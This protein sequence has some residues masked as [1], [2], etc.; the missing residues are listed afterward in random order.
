MACG[1]PYISGLH[2]SA[3]VTAGMASLAAC[4]TG[5]ETLVRA[6]T[7]RHWVEQRAV[8]KGCPGRL[9]SRPQARKAAP[10]RTRH[11]GHRKN[12]P[13]RTRRRQTTE[14]TEDTEKNKPRRTRRWQTT[15]G[16]EDTEKNKPPRT[17]RWKR[18]GG[19]AGRHL[20]GGGLRRSA[21]S[22]GPRRQSWRRMAYRAPV[23]LGIVLLCR[24]DRRHGKPGG[25]LHLTAA[26]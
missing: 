13:Q 12:K 15:E 16:T 20:C 9:E 18:G 10:H 5:A 21:Q 11:G 7:A 23:H 26:G 4:S 25:L 8:G 2:C 3:G 24:R 22:W 17:R 1:L 19:H 14:G 6:Y